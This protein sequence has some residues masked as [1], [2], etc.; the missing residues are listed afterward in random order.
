MPFQPAAIETAGAF[1]V[2]AAAVSCLLGVHRTIPEKLAGP[3]RILIFV[4]VIFLLSAL[5]HD[6]RI[7]ATA[8]CTRLIPMLMIIVA[9]TCITSLKDL[10]KALTPVILAALGQVPDAIGMLMA[11][12]HSLP[13]VFQAIQTLKDLGFDERMS[14][15]AFTGF[16]STPA[17]LS[18]GMTGL[19]F[20]LLA[21]SLILKNNGGKVV[22]TIASMCLGFMV[23]L[24]IRRG[25][26]FLASAG[27]VAYAVALSRRLSQQLLVAL[28]ALAAIYG[29]QRIDT[30]E[31]L[32][33]GS[34]VKKRSD[35]LVTALAVEGRFADTLFPIIDYWIREDP[36]GSFLGNGGLE[37]SAFGRQKEC[38]VEVFAAVWVIEFGIAG[39]AVCAI[40]MLAFLWRVYKLASG[41]LGPSVARILALY[42]F[43]FFGL[44]FLKE[45]SAFCQ[46]T[47]GQLIF[48]SVPGLVVGLSAESIEGRS[49]RAQ[50]GLCHPCMA[51]HAK[52]CIQ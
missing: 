3:L 40:A 19:L 4:H 11:G 24:T 27:M 12:N 18:T 42:C 30:V 22:L 36:F 29:V 17:G 35:T 9:A 23:Y 45:A 5:L 39:A 44:S 7:G 13:S 41:V 20:L 21:T 14:V 43:G 46:V 33:A 8:V 38:S 6:W 2:L 10:T 16:A 28:S 26:L 50:L 52:I 37:A 49:V 25:M 51:R 48:W 32:T 31:V 1:V 47:L 15:G 34:E